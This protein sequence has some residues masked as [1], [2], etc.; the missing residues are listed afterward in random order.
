LIRECCI[1]QHKLTKYDRL[2]Y[3]TLFDQ[4]TGLWIIVNDINTVG[5][6]ICPK[7]MVL[8]N[9]YLASIS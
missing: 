5:R 8:K 1:S 3:T 4:A 6:N 2:T 9:T 7:E